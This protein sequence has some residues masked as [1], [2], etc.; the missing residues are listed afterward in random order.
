MNNSDKYYSS[1]LAVVLFLI[2]LTHLFSCTNQDEKSKEQKI[3][4]Q[5]KIFVYKST[6][7]GDLEM[8][9]H[10]PPG[11][12]KEDKRPA[13]VFFFGG[14][15]IKGSINQ[16]IPQAEYFAG[17]GMVAA[18]ADYRVKE[19]HGTLADKCVEDGKSAVRWLRENAGELGIDA[20]HIVSSGGSA[21]GHVAACTYSV[22][23]YENQEE[24]QTISSVPNLMVLFN[25]V[26]DAS[27]LEKRVKRMGSLQTA[28]ALSP[29][30][31]LNS[32]TPPTLMFYGTDDVLLEQGKIYVKKAAEL[33]FE[34]ILYTAEGVGHGFFNREP[35]LSKTIYLTD[36]FL[37][38]HGYLQ[39]NPTR[40]VPENSDMIMI[41]SLE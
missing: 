7:Q 30:L 29:N 33:N 22:D 21:G 17:R 8:I 36:R 11:W 25:P 20:M 2:V 31:Q 24:N 3:S 15:W 9:V 28:K 23:G 4:K 39:E 19:R 14:G 37:I 35:W 41:R 27:N 32:S 5:F 18:R 26:L 12:T 40:I 16:F 13:I 1:R 34:A 10:F 6:P 38:K